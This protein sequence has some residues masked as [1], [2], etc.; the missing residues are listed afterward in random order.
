MAPLSEHI[1]WVCNKYTK[2]VKHCFLLSKNS[3]ED[4]AKTMD[5]MGKPHL[6]KWFTFKTDDNVRKYQVLLLVETGNSLLVSS[7]IFLRYLKI[8]VQ[9]TLT[10]DLVI[11][12]SQQNACL[13]I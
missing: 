5:A 13:R 4:T 3:A 10:E 6:S 7:N 9:Q 2:G 1:T 8:L 11:K 12:G